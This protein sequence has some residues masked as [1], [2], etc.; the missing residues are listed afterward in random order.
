MIEP[1]ITEFERE[2]LEEID[3]SNSSVREIAH[4]LGLPL[5]TAHDWIG[6]EIDKGFVIRDN[7]QLPNYKHFLT[8]K[9]LAA[10]GRAS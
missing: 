10:I 8:D 4:N 6:R 3:I 2:L 5:S 7:Y 9:G 1:T